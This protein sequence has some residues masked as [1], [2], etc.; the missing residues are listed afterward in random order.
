M[1][2]LIILV[3]IL[4]FILFGSLKFKI[5]AII[6]IFFSSIIF[7]IITNINNDILFNLDKLL[8]N[9]F[10]DNI[11]T[12][13]P[14]ILSG[15]ILIYILSKIESIDN[16]INLTFRN[17]FAFYFFIPLIFMVISGV[18]F[19]EIALIAYLPI[20][21]KLKNLKISNKLLISNCS[22]TLLGMAV[23]HILFFPAAPLVLSLNIFDSQFGSWVI[24]FCYILSIVSISSLAFLVY[25]FYIR[26]EFT[27]LKLKS[28]QNDIEWFR[29]LIFILPFV[30]L[31]ILSIL[32]ASFD[33]GIIKFLGNPT[34]L[35]II[36]IV[37]LLILNA[38]CK[39]TSHEDIV[40]QEDAKEFLSTTF[41][42]V[43]VLATAMFFSYSII[44]SDVDELLS[45]ILVNNSSKYEMV[46]TSFVIALLFRVLL[47]S[48]TTSIMSASKIISPLIINVNGVYLISII[49]SILA[50]GMSIS[51][52]NDGGF[53]LVCSNFADNNIY[54][55]FKI[56][57]L[58]VFIYSLFLLIISIAICN[59]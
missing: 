22:L 33:K 42:V 51:H 35:F 30:S 49:L 34:L 18:S 43:G 32:G 8:K 47:G 45:N 19:F 58:P 52:L 24:I 12:I 5:N 28:E 23:G 11:S 53:W 36:W 14:I 4:I 7:V 10:G 6:L 2:D 38:F 40:S 16:F 59:M 21:L 50:G 54:K 44:L 27:G 46:L 25:W 37:I 3:F 17:V 41:Y 31:V 48:T 20:F 15:S 9:G 57:T 55:T 29:A 13:G 39:W 56:W 1:I 26:K